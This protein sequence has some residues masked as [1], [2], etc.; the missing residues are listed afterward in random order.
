MGFNRQGDEL[1][2]WAAELVRAHGGSISAKR[3][4]GA[5]R[6][7][8]QWKQDGKYKSKYLKEGEVEAVRRQ[9]SILRGGV[10]APSGNAYSAADASFECDVYLGDRL[11]KFA[12]ESKGLGTRDQF[13]MIGDYLHSPRSSKVFLIYGLRRT[14][15][16]TMIRQS[17]LS[18]TDAELRRAAYVKV[19]SLN[20]IGELNRDLKRL[21]G[22]GI[23]IVYIDEV[24]LLEDFI[25]CASMFSDVHAALGMKIVLSGTDS[26]GFWFAL[27]E[28][29]YD[30]AIMMHTTFIPYRE[31]SRLL[32]TEDIDTYLEFGGTFKV[33]DLRFD[34]PDAR[35][36]EA[37]FRSEESTRFYIDTAIS[38][39]IQNSLKH[40]EGGG[41]F[42]KLQELY[43]AGELTN[44][45]NR[46][47][48]DMNHRF[49]VDV[50]TREFK[51]SDLGSAAKILIKSRDEKRRMDVR[52]SVDVH[53]VTGLLA[54]ILDVKRSEDAK[55]GVEAAH[56]AEIREYLQA[57]D[58]LHRLEI[59]TS[60]GG[61]LLQDAFSQPGMRYAQASA[62]V[63]ALGSDP[64]FRA[65][66]RDRAKALV[67][68]ILDDVRGRLE[69]EVVLME[70]RRALERTSN[71][72]AGYDVF[73]LQ[74][75]VGEFDM[76]VRD[77]SENTCRIFEIKHSRECIP[78]SQARHLRDDEKISVAESL[79][80]KVVERT[81]LYRGDD[82][83]VSGIRYRNVGEYLKALT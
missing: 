78:E 66:A 13:S 54:D 29:L 61:V 80:G 21:E 55:I 26:L 43:R 50:V 81:V 48:E 72:F 59:R 1:E 53:L 65:L 18:L 75:A 63:F 71:P 77:K 28:E 70:T 57:L 56:V 69:E 11:V 60:A 58:L 49:V 16:T 41:R 46:I 8:L 52:E 82:C 7:Y 15:K 51:S 73:K 3:I 36:D 37:A 9:L 30:R 33:G 83:D 22:M 67:E 6:Y 64:R 25:D 2:R 4:R 44:A 5:V 32:G 62:L 40:L 79:Y 68:C 23:D 42:R 17:I 47:V 38:R 76:V 74:F 14:G 19:E 20:R 45:I 34:H 39:N 24:T 10:S 27:H 35:R 31:H 12:A